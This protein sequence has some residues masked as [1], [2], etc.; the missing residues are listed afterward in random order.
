VNPPPP[1]VEFIGDEHVSRIG[2][3]ETPDGRPADH[4]SPGPFRDQTMQ[5]KDAILASYD[6]SERVVDR[7]LAD[8]SDADLLVRPVGGQNHIAWQLGH[9]IS[10]EATITNAIKPGSSPELPAG[11]T[12]AHARDEDSTKSDDRTRF[13]TKATYL[14][15]LKAQRAATKAVISGLSDADLDAPGPER[16]RERAP[17]VGAALLMGANHYL[18][19]VGQFVGVRRMLDKPIAI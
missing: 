14:N 8:L 9:L 4:F 16:M 11:F 10:T 18:M 2:S 3:A 15:L 1:H 6:F 19:H 12:Q 13:A 17:T 7:Y 5:A